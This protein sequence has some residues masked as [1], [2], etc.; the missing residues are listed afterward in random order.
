MC[1]RFRRRNKNWRCRK[2]KLLG[3]VLEYHR[4]VGIRC[5][6]R[7]VGLGSTRDLYVFHC[8]S[9]KRC[10]VSHTWGNTPRAS[11]RLTWFVSCLEDSLSFAVWC[12]IS[13]NHYFKN[14]F[15]IFCMISY[16]LQM[17]SVRTQ[18]PTEYVLKLLLAL[19]NVLEIGFQSSR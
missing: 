12:P 4:R 7:R 15:Y 10:A 1:W 13:E 2:K 16:L 3:G 5:P 6:S 18:N 11:T 9:M 14:N 17:G 8:Y 19:F